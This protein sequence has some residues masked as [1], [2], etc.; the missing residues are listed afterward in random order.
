MCKELKLIIRLCLCRIVRSFNF[1][2]VGVI[3]GF[4]FNLLFHVNNKQ[5]LLCIQ[6]GTC[7]NI[8]PIKS[9]FSFIINFAWL[10]TGSNYMNF[11]WYCNCCCIYREK[12]QIKVHRWKE[13]KEIV[14]N[15]R[16]I[17]YNS[18]YY[19]LVLYDSNIYQKYFIIICT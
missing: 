16:E 18:T 10:L 7:I 6:N 15:S 19:K 14:G 5:D 9:T 12:R 11:E 2:E 1:V 13:L 8:E 3:E 17:K 4:S